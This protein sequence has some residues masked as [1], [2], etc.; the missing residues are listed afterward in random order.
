MAA[1][2]IA[3]YGVFTAK[4]C[5]STDDHQSCQGAISP[6]FC[7]LISSLYG[8]CLGNNCAHVTI[9]PPLISLFLVIAL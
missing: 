8:R 6:D 7:N 5:A 1:T 3:H 4:L 2:L 9:E